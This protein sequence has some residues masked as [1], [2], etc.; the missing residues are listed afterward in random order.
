VA[1][2]E[3]ATIFGLILIIGTRI[4]RL[5]APRKKALADEAE[6]AAPPSSDE[7][8][9]FVTSFG[10]RPESLQELHMYA[11]AGHM[12]S[13]PQK[14]INLL[15][16]L[17]ANGLMVGQEIM[18]LMHHRRPLRDGEAIY[19]AV[20]REERSLKR[21]TVAFIDKQWTGK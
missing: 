4:A 16:S 19:I 10:L 14:T 17:S 3:Y 8:Y 12:E 7:R 15:H 18:A 11:V 9:A 5:C 6:P 2:S 13:F 20:V 21:R 1:V